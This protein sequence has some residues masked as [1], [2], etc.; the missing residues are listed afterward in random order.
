VA[1]APA[2]A[3]SFDVPFD[4]LLDR[5]R[6]GDASMVDASLLRGSG[7]VELLQQVLSASTEYSIVG[8]DLNGDIVLWNEGARR[9]FG[10]APDEVID[11][12]NWDLLHP[13]EDVAAGRMAQMLSAAAGAGKWE[14]AVN[15]VRKDGSILAAHTELTPRRSAGGAAI[16]FMMV[17]KDIS[18]ELRLTHNVKTK[19]SFT[20]MFDS[21]MSPLMITDP[22]GAIIDINQQVELLTGRTRD[23]LIGSAFKDHFTKADSA[24][25]VTRLALRE[26]KVN[27]HELTVRGDDHGD[28]DVLCS[29]AAVFHPTGQLY[30]VFLALKDITERKR[31]ERELELKNLALERADRGKDRF[32][33]SMSHELRNPL[34][35]MLGYTGALIMGMAGQPSEELR[36]HLLTVQSAGKYQLSIIND[37]LDLARIEDGKWVGDFEPVACRALAQE[38]T[39]YL[40]VL[41]GDKALRLSVVA[42]AREI[43]I[44]TDRRSLTQILIN[45]VSN[46][47]KFTDRGEVRLEIRRRRVG[48]A[49]V[50]AFD[51]VDTGI[52]LAEEDQAQL[53][54]ALEQAREQSTAAHEG[55]GLG[56]YI[57]QRLATQLS[58]AISFESRLGGGSTFTL[59]LPY[60]RANPIAGRPGGAAG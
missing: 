31:H 3:G 41:A 57:S 47:I 17:S 46:A 22:L 50:V 51:V 15:L 48:R 38:L 54:Q 7:A 9:L 45:L 8:I 28:T 39:G 59:T 37:L 20:R 60:D 58:G 49:R 2:E 18:D 55:T 26:G 24:L 32:L 53:F 36:K 13:P 5:E 35:I 29:A 44:V 21:N 23:E 6:P 10:W 42:P 27:D 4:C 11:R 43:T 19:R 12:G 16:G 25:A 1:A 14:G 40:G 56:L 52:G 34:N 30:G 33:A